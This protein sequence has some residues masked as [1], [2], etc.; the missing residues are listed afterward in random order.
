M[1][2]HRN[3]NAVAKST[4]KT[5]K[6]TTNKKTSK[7]KKK[8]VVKTK[9]DERREGVQRAKQQGAT[10]AI[11]SAGKYVGAKHARDVVNVA[12]TAS[13][14]AEERAGYGN[15][16]KSGGTHTTRNNLKVTNTTQSVKR[17]QEEARI[18]AQ[19]ETV[20]E[21][22]YKS[23]AVKATQK[24]SKQLKNYEKKVLNE[25]ASAFSD[26]KHTINNIPIYTKWAKKKAEEE[27]NKQLKKFGD[28]FDE[29]VKKAGLKDTDMLENGM[30]VSQYKE[31]Q[32]KKLNKKSDKATQDV[33]KISFSNQDLY[34]GGVKLGNEMIDYLIPYGA[35][36]KGALKTADTLLAKGG[37]AGKALTKGINAGEK[38]LSA[39]GK[40][41]AKA[42]AKELIKKN[43]G[44]TA[45]ILQDLGKTVAK[46]DVK[47]NIKREVV[48]NAIQDATLGTSIDLIKGMQEGYS[49]KDL[50][51]YMGENAVLNAV[52]GAPVSAVAGR[53]GKAGKEAI[54]REL[55]ESVNEAFSQI[56]Q[57]TKTEGSEFIRLAKKQEVASLT[58][59]EQTRMSELES[60]VKTQVKG[61]AQIDTKGK[62]I[63][64]DGGVL[65][66]VAEPSEVR[67]LTELKAKEAKGVP[68]TAQEAGEYINLQK[69]FGGAYQ[70]VQTNALKAVAISKRFPNAIGLDNMESA[71][72]FAKLTGD[73]E[74]VKSVKQ[75][76]VDVVKKQ[77]N[78][79]DV[80]A[81]LIASTNERSDG[82][83][84]I[85]PLTDD[86]K[87]E[88]S[89]LDVD[90]GGAVRWLDYKTG[91]TTIYVDPHASAKKQKRLAIAHELGHHTI[92]FEGDKSL[93]D[94]VKRM[95][96]GEWDKMKSRISEA[97]EDLQAKIDRGEVSDNIKID[98]DEEVACELFAKEMGKKD[99]FAYIAGDNPTSFGKVRT[100]FNKILKS[101]PSFE[102]DPDIKELADRLKEAYDASMHPSI[103]DVIDDAMLGDV[104]FRLDDGEGFGYAPKFYSKMYQIVDQRLGKGKRIGANPVHIQR[105]F[106]KKGATADEWKFSGMAE[107]LKGRKSVTKEELLDWLKA[108]SL[109]LDEKRLTFT[110]DDGYADDTLREFD[111]S[112]DVPP[113]GY[114]PFND[115]YE[116]PTQYSKYTL[117]NG[118]NYREVLYKMPDASRAEN[119]DFCAGEMVSPNLM[120]QY[121]AIGNYRSPHWSDGGVVLHSRLQDF[122][123]ANKD[124][125]VD[126][127]NGNLAEKLREDVQLKLNDV[128]GD[129]HYD[130]NIDFHIDVPIPNSSKRLYIDAGDGVAEVFVDTSLFNDNP[131]YLQIVPTKHVES[132]VDDI[133]DAVLPDIKQFEGG[134]GVLFIDEIQSD[135]HNKG[136]A[137]GYRPTQEGMVA[138]LENLSGVEQF[139]K[140]DT[141]LKK[142]PRAPYSEGAYVNY[143]LKNAIRE[144]CENGQDYVAWTTA[145]QQ[146]ERWSDD[147]I[148]AYTNEYD[149]QMVNFMNKYVGQFDPNTKVEKITLAE[150]GMDVWGI[151]IPENMRDSVLYNG[152][153]SFM[154]VGKKAKTGVPGIQK[155]FNG[156]I[157]SELNR[158]TE[159]GWEKAQTKLDRLIGNAKK[160]GATRDELIA[161]HDK[162]RK[163]TG[164]CMLPDGEWAFE[165]N[166]APAKFKAQMRLRK[167]EFTAEKKDRLAEL[168][169]KLD[170]GKK[171]TKKEGGEIDELRDLAKAETT[172]LLYGS[173]APLIDVLDHKTLFDAY[174]QLRNVTVKID[175]NMSPLKIEKKNGTYRVAGTY[176]DYDRA[177]KTIRLNPDL[178]NSKDFRQA[179]LQ[180][181]IKNRTDSG[182]STLLHE[183]QHAIQ[184]I[185]R[186]EGGYSAGNL[187]TSVEY[188]GK[189]FDISKRTIAKNPIDQKAIDDALSRVKEAKK[190]IDDELAS[191]PDISSRVVEYAELVSIA[192]TPRLAGALTKTQYANQLYKEVSSMLP[193]LPSTAEAEQ[194]V[195]Q[196]LEE[197]FTLTRLS[198]LSYGEIHAAY[199]E[200]IGETLARVTQSRRKLG[201]VDRANNNPI[202]YD[203]T[204][205]YAKGLEGRTAPTTPEKQ[206]AFDAMH[207]RAMTDARGKVQFQLKTDKGG[208]IE[209]V[210]KGIADEASKA[211]KYGKKE[212][213]AEREASIKKAFDAVYDER[214]GVVNWKELYQKLVNE[215][216]FS[217]NQ[218]K[219]IR[220]RLRSRFNKETT[221]TTKLE[222]F[223]SGVEE[224][225]IEPSEMT[226]E[227]FFRGVEDYVPEEEIDASVVD[228]ELANY[229]KALDNATTDE[230]RSAIESA[231][232][233]LLSETPADNKTA[234]KN[235]LKELRSRLR[236]TSDSDVRNKLGAQIGELE[237]RLKAVEEPEKKTEE[238]KTNEDAIR[239]K[240]ALREQEIADLE[241]KLKRARSEETITKLKNQIR[242]KK[243]SVTR[244]KK[245]IGEAPA[246]KPK[247]S[248]LPTEGQLKADREM[249][250]FATSERAWDEDYWA[251]VDNSGELTSLTR[252]DIEKMEAQLR[253]EEGEA[254]T[255]KAEPKK[256]PKPKKESKPKAEPKP[257]EE[258]KE[259]PKK[260]PAP[261]E[262]E[263]E[264]L[265]PMDFDSLVDRAERSI[266]QREMS[267]TSVR[268]HKDIIE[269]DGG[270]SEFAKEVFKE[271]QAWGK[272]KGTSNKILRQRAEEELEKVGYERLLD[273]F[274]RNADLN[275]D[276]LILQGDVLWRKVDKMVKSGEIDERQAMAD[277]ARIGEKV[278][279]AG[280]T[281]GRQLQRMKEFLTATP[282]GRA[283]AIKR[284]IERLEKKYAK[285]IEGG[286]LNV[287]QELIEKIVNATGDE[288]DELLHQLNLE[289]WNQIPA[290]LMER[291]NEYRHCFMLFN[292][293]THG[294]NVLGNSIF[295]IGRAFSDEIEMKMLQS[296][297]VKKRVAKLE[298]RDVDD[299]IIDKVHVTS[300]ELKENNALLT[301]EFHA[302]YDKSGSRNKFIELGRPDGVPTVKFKAMQKLIDLN[303]S[304]LEKEDL[305]GALI[306]AFNKAYTSYCKARCPKN[307]LLSDYM[308]NM[309][310]KEKDMARHYALLQGEYATFRDDCAFSSWLTGK[311]QTFAGMKGNTPFGTLGYRALD[312]ALEGALPFVKTPVNIFRRSVDFSPAS[313]LFAVARLKTAKTAEEF[314]YGVHQL[315]TGLT[316]TGVFGLGAFLAMN[317]LMTVKAGEES[318]DAYYDRDMGYQDYSVNINMDGKTYS[319]TLDWASPNQMSL[320]AGAA[321]VKA[322]K[323]G[324]N[325][326][327]LNALFSLSA[328]ATDTSFMSSP[329][330]TIERFIENAGRGSD[331]KEVDF[332]GAMAQLLM[333]DMPKNYVSGFMPQLTAQMAGFA[334]PTQRD[335]RGTAENS[336]IRGWQSAGRQMLNKSLTIRLLN[337]KCPVLKNKILNPKL[338]RFGDDKTTGN[339]IATR[340]VNAFLNPATVHEITE[341]KTDRELIKIRNSLDPTS[342]DYKYFYYNFTGNP[343]YKLKNGKRMTYDE[344]YTYGKSN[345]KFQTKLVEEM[346]NAN[347]YKNMTM[348]MKADE[349]DKAHWT[350]TA[351]AD[352]DTYGATYAIKSMLQS[353]DKEKEAVKEYR[354]LMEGS[355]LSKKKINENYMRYYID[356]ESM[357]ARSHATGDDVY[358][359]KGLVAIQRGDSTLLQALDI[360]KSKIND[361]QMYVEQAT[362]DAKEKGEKPKSFI[363]K[364][365]TD[366]Y[367]NI[368]SNVKKAGISSPSKG[369]KST[370]AGLLAV[371]G[372]QLPERVYRGMGHNW[373]SAQSGAGL[374]MKYNSDGK[375]SVKKIAEMKSTLRN[376]F[377]ENNSG[378]IN[379]NEVVHFIDSLGVSGDE[380]ACLYEVLYSGGNYKNPYK[381][382][383]DDHLKWKEN[384]DEEWGDGTSSGRGRR[385]YGGWGHHGG[386]GRGGKGKMPT[387]ASGAF[388]GK[389]TNPFA[390]SKTASASNLNEAYRKKVKR[391]REQ[392]RK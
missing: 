55:K 152:Q 115:S 162:V 135:L 177:T 71:V 90:D 269:K 270:S 289:L 300:K 367:C 7:T 148:K 328:P 100:Y 263:D 360:Q 217:P 13:K 201:A 265:R 98:I 232:A 120:H 171:L 20:K 50:G 102:K 363:Y 256:E 330:D 158:I 173:G 78:A 45:K 93:I 22:G 312:L 385:G 221:T 209:K 297:A 110:E 19:R 178:F 237:E 87:R 382:Q 106:M 272:V 235:S 1:A 108:N 33:G 149:T 15:R 208:L 207:P 82:G 284:E 370:S 238:A 366:G 340:F 203:A 27:K 278:S 9:G 337:S 250:D 285:R 77:F 103:G 299:V 266:Y 292:V 6:K 391:L 91:Q 65:N 80:S 249:T 195:K 61:V 16:G 156:K 32:L 142:V 141:I 10:K 344:A 390:S 348:E 63:A 331:G 140:L 42:T 371:N 2:V 29:Q 244:F 262:N 170:D 184:H 181:G 89:A 333:G 189:V 213:T 236:K 311:K 38:A 62:L 313:L 36:T 332:S 172:Q 185:E 114:D 92:E 336:I 392:T 84:V 287:N 124:A 248:E 245:Q 247:K 54:N 210:R 196:Y 387:T 57:L 341:N 305:K 358:R 150:N 242:G 99:I 126:N 147:F 51:K 260:E 129:Y 320:F 109:E 199:K 339:N 164:W 357:L 116:E 220:N 233:K 81:K 307:M 243:A 259:E 200:T 388:N 246:P 8:P 111:Y 163:E 131:D 355:D 308:K 280:S 37:K 31:S 223:R 145:K 258:P 309:S 41:L 105:F 304:I 219:A 127:A 369:V 43:G 264:L 282:E 276:E 119:I 222:D 335:T 347:S 186:W 286:K 229:Q 179:Q 216:K 353:N 218:A 277:Y 95:S 191:F 182:L 146:A 241:A 85:R 130:D 290:T 12:K 254:P 190:R 144:A 384:H 354:R 317:D 14:S 212:T 230:E 112:D 5:T 143:A 79:D 40:D 349:V 183:V 361:L 83:L 153:A 316:G 34:K 379:K 231:M 255:P 21:N 175:K 35:T 274:S 26:K 121:E 378:S 381:A 376:Q 59:A 293:K 4:A 23:G 104:R 28:D 214:T 137:E 166:D 310:A 101:D 107:F 52:I 283:V 252:E 197:A 122:H 94:T 253:A 192:Q 88:N 389:I 342:N 204:Y 165:I 117:P 44:D 315:A 380:A 188:G 113:D 24:A 73:K 334:D 161:I 362:A 138:Q 273:R 279:A 194:V 46:S 377:D 350:S 76:H 128:F 30:T 48:A 118:E 346:I 224:Q 157:T 180:R 123:V 47:Q 75:A 68:L 281:Y 372:E 234:L 167:Q 18:R 302:I 324:S 151:R 359:V 160:K 96:G 296:N 257:K 187:Y 198:R 325:Q 205:R 356:K 225:R 3:P 67:K 25:G 97:Y 58:P 319:W 251:D 228:A 66:A 86:V 74:L 321:F 193:S 271:P 303:Y 154:L 206:Q 295:R 326:D 174:P 70:A 125:P 132:A 338:D 314:Q 72:N 134:D 211:S 69:K 239:E 268:A 136:S 60:K 39:S 291:M 306:P 374:M 301:S 318:G 322:F 155:F 368:M 56:N 323:S 329:K 275:D 327:I 64:N 383:I 352:L 169:A 202:D 343:S 364:E 386:G 227:E 351:K 267:E 261:E 226:D 17:K 365:W 168:E 11:A 288:K 139:D 298:G 373:N 294:R 345:R 49:G 215:E 53:A 375:Y 133:V 176:G 159:G 240:I